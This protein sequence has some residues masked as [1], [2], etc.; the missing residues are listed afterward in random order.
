MLTQSEIDEIDQDLRAGISPEN[1]ARK[2]GSTYRAMR[3]ALL[4]SG[5]KWKTTRYLVDTA[6]AEVGQAGPLEMAR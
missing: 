1:I 5:K 2:R 3:L 4:N 6:P